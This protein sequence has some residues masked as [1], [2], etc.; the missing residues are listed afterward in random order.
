GV[1]INTGLAVGQFCNN[2]RRQGQSQIGQS[3]G[4][5]VVNHGQQAGIAQ[6]YLVH[7]AGSRVALIGSNHVQIQGAAQVWQLV[8]K[9]LYGL[10]CLLFNGFAVVLVTTDQGSA[11]QLDTRLL[12]QR[13]E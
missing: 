10:V 13:I 2:A 4:D 3:V 5:A 8:G 12:Q 11:L 7:I 1:N 9:G 6:Q